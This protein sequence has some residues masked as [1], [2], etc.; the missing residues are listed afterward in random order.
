MTNTSYYKIAE[1]PLGQFN[2][3]D[4]EKKSSTT[5]EWSLGREGGLDDP[6]LNKVGQKISTPVLLPEKKNDRVELNFVD[7]RINVL[8]NVDFLHQYVSPSYYTTS[9]AYKMGSW[10]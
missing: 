1:N 9:T 6:F 10:K 7:A 3:N 4:D 8:G 2:V 5:P